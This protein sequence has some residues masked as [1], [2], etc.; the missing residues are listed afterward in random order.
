MALRE[1]L[2]TTKVSFLTLAMF[3]LTEVLVLI[4]MA[5]LALLSRKNSAMRVAVGKTAKRVDISMMM[6]KERKN[7]S[8]DIV[9]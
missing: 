5:Y 3:C 4:I 9:D 8:K 7:M 2:C 1:N 6:A